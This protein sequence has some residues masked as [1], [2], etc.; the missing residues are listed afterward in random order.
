MNRQVWH[1]TTLVVPSITTNTIT[2]LFKNFVILTKL[3]LM[4]A[5]E[6]VLLT[7]SGLQTGSDKMWSKWHIIFRGVTQRNPFIERNIFS[8]LEK[9]LYDNKTTSIS[10]H[11]WV[12]GNLRER[13]HQGCR[14]HW[15]PEY[16]CRYDL[17]GRNKGSVHVGGNKFLCSSLVTIW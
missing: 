11:L 1:G 6:V 14:P 17:E 16:H 9:K 4:G 7:I 8:D 12:I 2:V 3:F 5:P 10:L 13:R 15:G